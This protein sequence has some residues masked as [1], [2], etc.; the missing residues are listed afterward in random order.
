LLLLFS[1]KASPPDIFG[2]ELRIALLFLAL[3]L[4][5]RE[6]IFGLF[7][8][9]PGIDRGRLEGGLLLRLS[10]NAI[11]DA[12]LDLVGIGGGRVTGTYVRACVSAKI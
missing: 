1:L 10:D 4:L 5:R 2:L 8:R 9:F 6:R 11:R 12:T 3:Y 7:L